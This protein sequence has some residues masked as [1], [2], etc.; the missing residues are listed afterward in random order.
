MGT[1]GRIIYV[2]P[3]VIEELDCIQRRKKLKRK[4]DALKEMVKY[5][6]AGREIER[7]FLV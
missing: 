3:S 2:P 4:A 5:S 1:K 7:V 6:K